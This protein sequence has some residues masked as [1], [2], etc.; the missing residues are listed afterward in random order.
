MVIQFQRFLMPMRD[1]SESVSGNSVKK[2]IYN[3]ALLAMVKG[4]YK[5]RFGT[6]NSSIRVL[7]FA[8][9]LSNGTR[10]QHFTTVSLIDFSASIIFRCQSFQKGKRSLNYD[11]VPVILFC[12]G[13]S[14]Y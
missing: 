5:E 13:P 6:L 7:K 2:K 11:Q 3:R 8:D 1:G 4:T 12:S 14:R 9:D 10:T